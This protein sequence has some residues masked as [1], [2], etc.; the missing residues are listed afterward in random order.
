MPK[1]FQI[2]DHLSCAKLLPQWPQVAILTLPEGCS[3]ASTPL[4]PILDIF[5]F[6]HTSQFRSNRNSNYRWMDGVAE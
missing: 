2:D 4:P 6:L 1:L 5:Q 3:S